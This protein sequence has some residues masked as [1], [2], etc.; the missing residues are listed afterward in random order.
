M[1]AKLCVGSVNQ[2]I[3]NK[4]MECTN[5]EESFLLDDLGGKHITIE[6]GMYGGHRHIDVKVSCPVCDEEIKWGRVREG[7]LMDP[8]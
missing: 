4:A 8:P 3:N 5:C 1:R 7:E 2:L 6:T